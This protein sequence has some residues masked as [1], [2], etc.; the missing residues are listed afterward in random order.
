MRPRFY[1]RFVDA[2]FGPCRGARLPRGVRSKIEQSSAAESILFAERWIGG[3]DC[4]RVSG[5]RVASRSA[6]GTLR[7]DDSR[8]REG[9]EVAASRVLLVVVARSGKRIL[10]L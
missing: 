7:S 2:S 10:D 9:R 3:G 4:R 1:D 6:A 8:W 5:A